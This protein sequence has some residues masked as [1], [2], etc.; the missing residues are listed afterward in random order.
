MRD[1][2]KGGSLRVLMVGDAAM[3][4]EAGLR[5]ERFFTEKFPWWWGRKSRD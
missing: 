2:E 1:T 5:E 3:C 4:W